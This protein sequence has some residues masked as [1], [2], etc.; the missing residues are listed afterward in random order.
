MKKEHLTLLVFLRD[1][2]KLTWHEVWGVFSSME[3]RHNGQTYQ[4]W[5]RAAKKDITLDFFHKRK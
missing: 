2:L 4:R 5:Y 1:E 3:I